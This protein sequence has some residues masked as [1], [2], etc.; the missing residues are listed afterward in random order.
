MI[1]LGPA[2]TLELCRD[3]DNPFSMADS[4]RAVPFELDE[5]RQLFAQYLQEY[6]LQLDDQIIED[7][8][9]RTRG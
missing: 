5:V 6:E 1:L 9:L 4:I 8:Y 2:R 7:V 3:I